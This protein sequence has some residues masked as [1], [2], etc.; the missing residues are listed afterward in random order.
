M[1]FSPVF[2]AGNVS[3]VLPASWSSQRPCP[4]LGKPG[5][6]VVSGGPARGGG[7][8][9]LWHIQ[10]QMDDLFQVPGGV[11]KREP[12]S[13]HCPG[14]L[15]HFWGVWGLALSNESFARPTIGTSSSRKPPRDRSTWMI[16]L[17]RTARVPSGFPRRRGGTL[18]PRL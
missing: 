14:S 16:R 15:S 2:V 6:H 7:P 18:S 17:P 13:R 12:S 3:S 4:S 9:G 1:F 11:A 10:E 8:G 5:S